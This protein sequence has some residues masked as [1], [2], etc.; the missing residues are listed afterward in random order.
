M[1]FS[2]GLICL[3][4]V[5]SFCAFQ[6]ARSGDIDHQRGIELRGG[7]GMYLNNSDPNTFV[8][9][10]TVLPGY[11]Q[12]EY[13]ESKGAF[14][15]GMSLLYKTRSYFTWHIGFNVIANDSAT[16]SGV[17]SSNQAQSARIFMNTVELFFTANYYWNLSPRFNLEFGAG[18]AFYLS[19]LDFEYNGT[20]QGYSGESISFY[21]AHGRSFGF[22]GSLGAEFFLSEVLSLKVGGGFRWAPV[23]RFKYFRE[24]STPEGK[25]TIGEI[26]YWPGT[27]NTFET[28]FSGAFLDVSL[29]VYFDP[30]APWNKYGHKES[31]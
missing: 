28:D 8:K 1:R 15:G 27:F 6:T 21:G 18:P 17:N 23:S 30:A 10:L 12:T 9:D 3:S 16:A 2:T 13:T 24:V 20:Y 25:E 29:R 31:D 4:I 14:S 19:S 11:S 7:Y 5:V 22:T 26:A